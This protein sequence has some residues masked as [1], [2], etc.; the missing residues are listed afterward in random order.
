MRFLISEKKGC[1]FHSFL[2]RN[3]F[4]NKIDIFFL[5]FNNILFH[6]KF[7]S[8]HLIKLEKYQLKKNK[9]NG[10][11]GYKNIFTL[12]IKSSGLC[13]N[14][15]SIRILSKN[16]ENDK[17]ITLEIGKEYSILI[18]ELNTFKIKNKG[19]D[20]IEN[21]AKSIYNLIIK[22]LNSINNS[23]NQSKK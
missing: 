6:S 17:P 18:Y 23:D 5:D 14:S 3:D 20:F 19:I 11:E 21:K 10:V 12:I 1:S 2:K 7:N 9:R 22:N 16:K 13:I 8:Y 15:K 4:L